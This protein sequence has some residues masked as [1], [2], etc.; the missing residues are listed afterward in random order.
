MLSF[1]VFS[2]ALQ[3]EKIF[4]KMHSIESRSIIAPENILFW[5]TCVHLSAQ[6]FY[7]GSQGVKKG[8]WSKG[9]RQPEA[10][11]SDGLKTENAQIL[12]LVIQYR[13][14]KKGHHQSDKHCNCFKGNTEETSQS[15]GGAH[16]GLSEHLDIILNW[17]EL[18][19]SKPFLILSRKILNLSK[20]RIYPPWQ[21]GKIDTRPSEMS[22]LME[23]TL[24]VS[25]THRFFAKLSQSA[26][27]WNSTPVKL[28]AAA[29]VVRAATHHQHARFI[30]LDIMF[31]H[32]TNDAR[33]AL[34]Q[35]RELIGVFVQ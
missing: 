30:K 27:A 29:D 6:K 33:P 1:Y 34:T 10:K 16:M 23:G 9:I 24:K 18:T 21:Q 3:C 15:Q 17:T 32:S 2:Y 7:W 28:H 22:T 20:I 25:C 31:L 12:H 4:I 11:I 13:Y 35:T 5:C 26:D 8:N 14:T 19:D